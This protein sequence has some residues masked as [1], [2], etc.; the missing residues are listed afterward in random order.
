[1]MTHT[2]PSRSLLALALPVVLGSSIAARAACPPSCAIPGGGTAATDCQAEFSGTG[3][4]LN[5]KPFDP[6]HPKPGKEV[7]CFDGDATCDTDGVADNACVFDVD[8]CLRNADPNLPL[9]TPADV[10]AVTVKGTTADPEL[11]ALQSALSGLLPATSN[12]CTSGR[13]LTVPLKG[14]DALGRFK[15]GK[16][17]VKLSA[18]TAGGIDADTLKLT[19]LPRGWPSHGYDR[20]NSRATPLE[21]TLSP[22][23]AS[24]LVQKWSL[25]LAAAIGT[26]NNAVTGTPAVG[27]GNVYIGSW[28]GFVVAV[29]QK[30]GTIKWK[31]DTQSQ[32]TP[33]LVPGVSGS[34]TLTADGR[35][36]AGDSNAMLH[37]LNAKNGKL[38]W[39]T[40]LREGLASADQVWASPTVAGNRVFIGVASHSDNPCT[41]GRLM[42]LD[43]DTGAILWSQ[44]NVPA[45]ICT[46][47][48]AITCAL[49]ADCP[50]GGTCVTGRGAGVTATVATDQSGDV[51]YMNTVG[52]YTFP[53]IGD[54]DSLFKLDAATGTTIWKTR[55]TPP[56]Q[57]AA[58]AGDPSVDCRGSADCA[59]VGGPCNTK[60]F[61]HDF[62]F[63]N[64]PLVVEADDGMSG[65]RELVVSGSKDGSL[66]ALDPTTGAPLWVRAV[67][68]VPVTPS[69][70]GFGLFDG[71]VG[72]A[73]VGGNDRFFAALYDFTPPLI[74]PPKHLQA[75]SAVD[76]S[77]AWE[78]E[79]GGSFSGVGIG[80]GL[81]AM[82]TL[83]AANVYVYDAT[84]GVRLKTLP[85]PSMT[86]AG[87][88][89]VDGTIY[90]GY[91]LGGP[92]G[93]LVAFGLP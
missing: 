73:H 20:R 66:Y 16:K 15:L 60:A 67:R 12:V 6:L 92:V 63:L 56:E 39:K 93:G 30:S 25:D 42:A 90:V 75:F 22:A 3:L 83:S 71:A 23:N 17:K 38:L 79:I 58:C 49:D 36:L 55:V 48:T 2:R 85:I 50:N 44:Q 8:V 33:G 80:G 64:G 76:G 5:Y 26:N 74:G 51:V 31:Y 65:T 29:K 70:A 32:S 81:V 37:C 27:F 89:I 4:R 10:S 21:T 59:F 28:N 34:V 57:F 82:G 18:V 86:S 13:T 43:L 68:P 53:S 72:F 41:N 84:T 61:Y 7:R 69:F 11:A 54:S 88:S 52:C 1:M 78:D 87:P 24:G 19:C 35:A 40:D 62:G 45:K 9:C 47:D 14:P 91:G 77:T 46:T